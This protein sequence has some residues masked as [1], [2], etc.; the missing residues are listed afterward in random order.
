MAKRANGDIFQGNYFDSQDRHLCFFKQGDSNDYKRR[1][2]RF[3]RLRGLKIFWGFSIK[4]FHPIS[5][6]QQRL[7]SFFPILRTGPK[8]NMCEYLDWASHSPW[9]CRVWHDWVIKCFRFI[10]RLIKLGTQ[11]L[12]W[13]SCVS[14]PKLYLFSNWWRWMLFNKLPTVSLVT[15]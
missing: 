6:S 10:L 8:H 1:G 9:G 4:L 12:L 2:S 15:T 11:C 3:S 14:A 7:G 5:V 13:L